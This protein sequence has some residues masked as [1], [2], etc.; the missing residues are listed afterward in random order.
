M[1]DLI[2]LAG[3]E[4]ELADTADYDATLDVS[5]AKRRVAALRRRLTFP[6]LSGRGEQDI[7]FAMQ[8]IEIELQQALAN[9]RLDEMTLDVASGDL[10]IDGL[11]PTASVPGAA[12]VAA[13]R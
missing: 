9:R 11:R 4:A 13:R 8:A 6:Q 7:A 10:A 3:I 2:T 5:N 12:G 1:A